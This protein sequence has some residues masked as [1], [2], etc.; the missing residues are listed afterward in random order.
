MKI[1]SSVNSTQKAFNARQ[2]D[3]WTTGYTALGQ[4]V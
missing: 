2:E 4:N 1:R 3:D